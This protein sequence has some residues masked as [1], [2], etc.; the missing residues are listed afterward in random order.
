MDSCRR[1]FLYSGIPLAKVNEMRALLELIGHPLTDS[2][3]LRSFIPKILSKE[4]GLLKQELHGQYFSICFDGTTR[5]AI[6]RGGQSL[7][8]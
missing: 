4:V 3:H 8:K 6:G 7:C 2:S 5:L 1:A